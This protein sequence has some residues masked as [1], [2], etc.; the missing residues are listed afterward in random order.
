M[1]KGKIVSLLMIAFLLIAAVPASAGGEPPSATVTLASDGM[2]FTFEGKGGVYGVDYLVEYCDGTEELIGVRQSSLYTIEFEKEAF[3]ADVWAELHEEFF[4]LPFDERECSQPGRDKLPRCPICGP[5]E[6]ESSYGYDHDRD[7]IPDPGQEP[8]LAMAWYGADK[9]TVDEE[10]RCLNLDTWV[11]M[12][13]DV[14]PIYV[15]Y[16]GECLAPEERVTTNGTWWKQNL[17]VEGGGAIVLYGDATCTELWREMTSDAPIYKW[18][19]CSVAPGWYS[20]NADGNIIIESG[21]NKSDWALWALNE[22]LFE[23]EEFPGTAA[24][25]WADGIPEPGKP[26]VI[27][28]EYP[29]P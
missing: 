5:A 17:D 14:H 4:G 22:G 15:K 28:A 2:S 26:L 12:W 27:G 29:L 1:K 21:Q 8:G 24:L 7:S 20:T 18:S 25:E 11:K 10:N 16:Y 6:W 3:Y 9:C 19:A 13:T 23:G